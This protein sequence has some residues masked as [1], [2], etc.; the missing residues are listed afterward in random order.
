MKVKEIIFMVEE[1]IHGGFSAQAL[2]F[3]IFTEAETLDG[4][5]KNIKDAL[6]C[7]FDKKSEI[8]R[9]IRL[10]IVREETLAYA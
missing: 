4:L 7:H 8:P 3:S 10:H 9:I 1:D 2:G 5:K 6:V